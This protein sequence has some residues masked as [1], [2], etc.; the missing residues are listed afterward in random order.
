MLQCRVTYNVM[1]ILHLLVHVGLTYKKNQKNHLIYIIHVAIAQY[2]AGTQL[3]E[4]YSS[5]QSS[6]SQ[7]HTTYS[8]FIAGIG[9]HRGVDGSVQLLLRHDSSVVRALVRIT[10]GHGFDPQLRCLNFF[11]FSIPM[12]VL[13]FDRYKNN[14]LFE[15]KIVYSVHCTSTAS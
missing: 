9:R 13:S 4:V 11:R 12:S 15:T 14:G 8:K 10:R 6:V 7:I 2:T 1:Y 5:D 3:S